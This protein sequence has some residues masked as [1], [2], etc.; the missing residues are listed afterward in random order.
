MSLNVELAR[1][2]MVE[3]QIRPWDVLDRRILEALNRIRREDY[4]PTAY[5]NLAFADLNVPLGHGEVM[6]KPIV[7]GRMLQALGVTNGD[8][9]LEIG[10]GS[11]FITACLSRLACHVHSVE[12]QREFAESAKQ[13]LRK[14]GFPNIHIEI[15][16]AVR[17][18]Y[19]DKPFDVVVLTGAV[20]SLPDTVRTW[21][22]PGGRLFAIQG[23]S[24]AMHAVLH[25]RVSEQEWR[26]ERLF[27]TDLPYLQH[28]EPPKCFSL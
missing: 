26:E 16:D 18:F 6:M 27:E 14:A 3:Q 19:F 4:V 15:T 5:R 9:V 20:Y 21:V 13:R 24:P 28:A 11:G 8:R 2:N 10:T 22:K 25:R 23:E 1:H 7:E 12:S 17:D